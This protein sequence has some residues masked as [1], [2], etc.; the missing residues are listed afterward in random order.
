M[1]L[2]DSGSTHNFIHKRVAE[3]VHF[4]VQAVSNFE[5]LIADG[6]IMKCE[7]CCENFKLQMEDYHL[8]TH[9]FVI[10]MCGCDIVLGVE[11]FRTLG[12]ITMDFQELYMSFKQNDH[13]H[14]LRG[15]QVGAPTIISSHRMEKLLKKGH[16][17]VV[18]QF[19]VI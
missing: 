5:V 7:G 1:V 2:I 19:N 18:P 12:H 10:E 6:G 17:G 16:H 4:F 15:L 13:I 14:T 3:V 11:W 9:M 8:K